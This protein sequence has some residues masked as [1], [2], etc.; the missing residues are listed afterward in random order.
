MRSAIVFMLLLISL[1]ALAE[2]VVGRAVLGRELVGGAEISAYPLTP[3]GFG[4]LTGEK[5]AATVKTAQDGTYRLSLKPGQYVLEAVK[6][7]SPA[8]SQRPLP[9]DL[10]SLH[11]ANPV[12]VVKG[13]WTG[14]TFQLSK[15]AGEKRARGESSAIKGRLT[16]KGEPA[17]R[18][19]LYFYNSAKGNFK[20]PA[21]ILQPVE[22]GSFSVRVAPGKYFLIGRKRAKGGST[23]PVEPGDLFSFYPLNPVTVG[24]GEEAEVEVELLERLEELVDDLNVSYKG[25]KVKVVGEKG[26]PLGGRYVLA[27]PKKDRSGPPLATGGPTG[28]DG[29]VYLN[30]PKEAVYLRVRQELGGKPE[31]GESYGDAELKAGAAEIQIKV[32]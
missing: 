15:V 11:S 3:G 22:K 32:R 12:T 31:E 30:A 1:P 26:E 29:T 8:K 19:Y 14:L 16:H 5:P 13:K 25:V 4:P 6:R 2:G 9:G 17:S 27:Y 20:G 28:P 10:Y 18:A 24:Q 23:G 21:D 7:S